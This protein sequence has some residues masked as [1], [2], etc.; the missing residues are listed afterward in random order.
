MDYSYKRHP[1]EDISPTIDNVK[2]SDAK[3][4]RPYWIE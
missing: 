2:I 3:C 4:K 1:L